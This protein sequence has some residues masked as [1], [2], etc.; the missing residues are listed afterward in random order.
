MNNDPHVREFLQRMAGEINA[1]PLDPR[2]PVKRARRHR[3]FMVAVVGV[4]GVAIAAVEIAAL[5]EDNLHP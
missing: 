5:V 2:S 3:S 4:V 1:S